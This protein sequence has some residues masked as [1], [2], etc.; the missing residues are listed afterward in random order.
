MKSGYA[1]PLPP[2][3]VVHLQD[4]TRNI[5]L[6]TPTSAPEIAEVLKQFLAK[7]LPESGGCVFFPS[8][9]ELSEVFETPYC[10]V[11]QA[12]NQLRAEGYDYSVPGLYGE[13]TL[14]DS[15]ASSPGFTGDSQQWIYTS[16]S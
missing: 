15:L 16:A 3:R 2:S 14:L 5:F 13:I 6:K 9:I 8:L 1:T 11:Q 7:H 4:F 10:E 12:L